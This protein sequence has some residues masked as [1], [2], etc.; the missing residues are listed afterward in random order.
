MRKRK[1]LFDEIVKEAGYEAGRGYGLRFFKDQDT[2]KYIATVYSE[3]IQ[4][5]HIYSD[6]RCDVELPWTVSYKT[7]EEAEKAAYAY[8]NPPPPPKLCRFPER[9]CE[10][11]ECCG[12]GQNI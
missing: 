10:K 6:G 3:V 7:R 5:I 2:G 4:Q 9:N 12:G 11:C 1:K 8:N